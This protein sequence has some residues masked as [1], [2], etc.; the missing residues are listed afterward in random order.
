MDAQM[1]YE[2]RM[3]ELHGDGGRSEAG[4]NQAAYESTNIDGSKS[5]ARKKKTCWDSKD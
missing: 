2:W 3:A 5:A 4:V 1:T